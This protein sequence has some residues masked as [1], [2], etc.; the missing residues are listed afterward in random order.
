MLPPYIS[1]QKKIFT[2][3]ENIF[4]TFYVCDYFFEKE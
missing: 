3:E 4:E 1:E 2:T